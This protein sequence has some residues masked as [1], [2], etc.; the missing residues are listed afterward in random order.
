MT[1]NITQLTIDLATLAR[2]RE[3]PDDLAR[4]RHRASGT[5]P[6]V[7]GFT[8]GCAAGAV[9]EVHFGLWA[10]ALPAALAALAVPLG[11]PRGAGRAPPQDGERRKI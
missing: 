11:E 9:L 1:A 8:A 10:L 3:E 2:G 4:A 7:A 6:C 5:F